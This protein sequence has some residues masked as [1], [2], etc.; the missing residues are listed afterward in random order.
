M[1]LPVDITGESEEPADFETASSVASGVIVVVDVGEGEVGL[2]TVGFT[3]GTIW[4]GLNINDAF[5]AYSCCVMKFFSAVGLT[6]P[7]IP[8]WIQAPG[9]EQ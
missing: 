7:T 8:S 4:P 5:L 2:V 9:E 6:T 1:I 3:S